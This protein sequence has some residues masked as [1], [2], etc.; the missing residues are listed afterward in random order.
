MPLKAL[1]K[2]GGGGAGLYYP[3]LIEKPCLEKLGWVGGALYKF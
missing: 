3:H 1:S 2:P